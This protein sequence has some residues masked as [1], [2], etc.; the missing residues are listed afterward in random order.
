VEEDRKPQIEAAIVRT[1]KSRKVGGHLRGRRSPHSW[2]G[3][4]LESSEA[5]PLLPSGLR[6]AWCEATLLCVALLCG[7]MVCCTTLEA[8]A[9]PRSQPPH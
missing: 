6:T 1:M 4:R 9:S 2:G 5:Q 8:V 3:G 7:G